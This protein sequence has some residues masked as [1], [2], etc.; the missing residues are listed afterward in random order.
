MKSK[1]QKTK[2][3]KIY[4]VL[5]AIFIT[6]FII[7]FFFILV[8]NSVCK[9]IGVILLICGAICGTSFSIAADIEKKKCFVGD[10]STWLDGELE[11]FS[12][13]A[14]A[15]NLNLYEN[16][17]L[18]SAELIASNT[19]DEDD[20]DWACNEIYASRNGSREFGFDAKDWNNACNFIEQKLKD[21]LSSGKKANVLKQADAVAFGFVDGDLKIV[22]R[23]K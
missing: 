5:S 12:S 19:F 8:D 2:K 13:T 18:F 22:Y 11:I 1:R 3:E 21:Y 14:K 6:A 20:D 16:K 15:F 9:A 17:K 4:F 23:K 10:F 7:S